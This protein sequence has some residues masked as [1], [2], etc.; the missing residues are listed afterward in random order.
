MTQVRTSLEHLVGSHVR[1]G[2]PSGSSGSTCDGT[3]L[4]CGE[5]GFVVTSDMGGR[6]AFRYTEVDQVVELPH[7]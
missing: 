7:E 6:M 3:V 1:I 5:D 2:L 4:D